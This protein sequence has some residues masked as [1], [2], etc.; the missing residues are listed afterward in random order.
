MG[1]LSRLLLLPIQ[2]PI[3]AALWAA[4]KVHTAALDAYHDPAAIK[5]E[6]VE[7]EQQLLSGQ[8]DEETYEAIELE[9]LQR[10]KDSRARPA[11]DE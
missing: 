3:D 4:D 6:L 1:L 5:R 7:L 8:I 11:E 10:L 2:G 9:L